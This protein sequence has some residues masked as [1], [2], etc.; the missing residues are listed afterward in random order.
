MRF[1]TAA[2]PLPVLVVDDDSALIR[3]LSDI[4]RL[5]GYAPSTA[6]TGREGLAQAA[7]QAPALA[8]VDLRLPDMDGME[9]AA[10]LHALSAMTEVVVLT[11]NAS[12]ESAVAALRE[13]SVDYLLKPVNVERLLQVASIATERW[14]RRHAEEKLRESDERFRRV[15]QSDMLGITFIGGDGVIEDANDA[16]LKI[17]GYTRDDLQLGLVRT[18][19]LTPKEFAELDR[20]KWAEMSERGIVT[21]YE[22]EYIRKDGRRVPVLIGA[23]II[24]TQRNTGVAFV[25]DITTRKL[26]ERALM[27][28]AAQQAAVASFGERALVTDDPLVLFDAAAKLVAETLDLPFCGVME[29]KSDGAS[30]VLRAGVGWNATHMGQMTTA[31]GDDTQAGYTLARNEPTIVVDMAAEKRFAGATKLRDHGIWSGITVVIPGPTHAYGVLAAHDIRAREFSQDDVYFLQAIAHVLGTAV[32]RNRTERAFRQAQRLEAVGR[33]ASGV[34]HDFNN[35]LTAITGYGEMVKATLAQGDERIA[36]VDE[37]LK[38]AGRAAGLTRQL[39]AFSRQ[40]VLQPR[41][42]LLNDIVTGIEKML[43]RLIAENIELTTSLS[44]D[45]GWVKADPGQIEQVILNLC[46]NARD[47]MPEGGTLTIETAN[48]E[49]D[50]AQTS[51]LNMEAPG[52]YIML[53]VT[54]TG[55]GMD[56]ETKARIFEPFF[57]TKPA[58]QGTG[59]GLATVYGIVKQ[60]GGEIWVYSEPGRGTAFKVFLPKMDGT[61]EAEQVEQTKPAAARGTETILLAEDEDAIRKV[62]KR[63]L[64]RAGYTVLTA[65]NGGEADMI[66]QEHEGPIH[67][68]VTDMVMPVMN[69]KQLAERL[70]GTRREL[71]VLFLSGYTDTAV[72]RQGLLQNH[73]HF[74]QKPFSAEALARKVRDVLDARR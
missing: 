25:L 3:T 61:A 32:E 13:H 8:V 55:T 67:L 31:T 72:A 49:L 51:E 69:G 34:S 11:G 42:V 9:L 66:S 62:A 58:D 50:G 53:A 45:L 48:V 44:P 59:L 26:A 24:D 47:A 16:F 5:H 73:A 68:L 46:V 4:L 20:L 33:L 71:T 18:S 52:S 19:A 22:K 41:M 29:R 12:V 63:I 15:V 54:D 57:T 36:D 39:L 38:A 30:L 10:K 28:R 17:V 65:K 43:S 27:A 74:L 7:R 2:E 14:Q 21:P 70:R 6:G 35:M 56:A 23:S 1:V 37:I 64:E 60:S 40:Q